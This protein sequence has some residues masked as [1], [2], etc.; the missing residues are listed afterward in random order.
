VALLLDNIVI[1]VSFLPEI[2]RLPNDFINFPI[3]GTSILPLLGKLLID[4]GLFNL[5][6]FL[7][8]FSASILSRNCFMLFIFF[9][10]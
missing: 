2:L 10:N 3:T 5:S 9:D 6:D 1:P 7:F 8:L 4:S